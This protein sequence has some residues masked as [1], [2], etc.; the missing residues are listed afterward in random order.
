MAVGLA[1]LTRFELTPGAA[2][3]AL[4][5]W[6]ADVPLARI[7]GRPTVV[8]AVHPRCP[9]TQAS[10]TELFEA[11]THSRITP[12]IY[13]LLC[14]PAGADQ[15]WSD[16]SA[17]RNA[18]RIPGARVVRDDN[19]VLAHFFGACTSGQVFIF[20][21]SGRRTFQGGITGARGHVGPNAGRAAIDKLLQGSATDV[22]ETPV[23]GCPL[24]TPRG[25]SPTDDCDGSGQ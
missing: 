10:I 15:A 4:S 11:L 8:M 20:D 18:R 9:C 5:T 17:W 22:I 16:S 21:A 25:C 14:V 24:V 7:D 19:G 3:G 2:A 23:Y 6:P 1:A 13:I 12:S